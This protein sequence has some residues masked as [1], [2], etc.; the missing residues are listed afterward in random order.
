M[1]HMILFNLKNQYKSCDYDFSSID[2]TPY[3]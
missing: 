2:A 3:T 1:Y